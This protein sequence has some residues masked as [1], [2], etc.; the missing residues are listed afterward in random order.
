MSKITSWFQTRSK[1]KVR[2]SSGP[3]PLPRTRP[4][5]LTPTPSETAFNSSPFFPK[6]SYELRHAIIAHA[7]GEQIV[8]MN[9]FYHERRPKRP[10]ARGPHAVPGKHFFRSGYVWSSSV[11]HQCWPGA[12][13]YR[14]A[15]G[16]AYDECHS[17][18]Q[19]NCIAWPG[20]GP[21][22]CFLGIMGWML[23]CRQA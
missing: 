23:S 7:F 19:A 16:P 22:K 14:D 5:P 11:C 18:G 10:T 4:S 9:L 20:D 6:L 1:K 3:E 13:G 12:H 15:L 21:E 8:H 17:N 2:H